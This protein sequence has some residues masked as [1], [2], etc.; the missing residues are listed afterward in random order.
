MAEPRRPRVVVVGAGP[1]GLM[2]ADVLSSAGAPVTVLERMPSPGRKLLMAGRGGLNL[3]HGEPLP[4]F[5]SR[6]GAA[7]SWL[8][9][10]ITAFPPSTLVAFAEALGQTTFVGSSGRIFPKAM[11]ASPLLRALL[12]RLADRGVEVLVRHRWLDVDADGGVRVADAAGREAH[13]AADAVVL[14]LGGASW[15]RLGSDGSWVRI[16]EEWGIGITPLSPANAGIAVPWSAVFQERFAGTPLKRVRL[17][18]ANGR[19]VSGELMI[20]RAGVE[21]GAVYALAPDISAAIAAT[22]RAQLELDLRRDL[23]AET[24]TT[25]L[26]Q[27]RGKQSVTNWL[28]KAAGLAPVAIGLLR[29]IHGRDL[30]AD[31]ELLARAAKAL[32][33]TTTGFTGL[34][35]AISTAGGIRAD[36]IDDHLMLRKRPGV[37][38]AGEMLDWSAPTGGYLL[39]ACFASGFAAAQGVLSYLDSRH[40]TAP[41]SASPGG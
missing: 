36:E 18:M 23:D 32:P 20:T 38:V 22:G 29:E 3:T 21:G 37:F 7:E 4:T 14:A 25:R 27:P 13:I 9:P 30:P 28:R 8:E 11:K 1:A 12:G 39:Q 41:A 26:A 15:P 40:G 6:Y 31:A 2:A 5:M 17:S 16:L 24:L 33:I 19:T 34:E 35:R 10:I